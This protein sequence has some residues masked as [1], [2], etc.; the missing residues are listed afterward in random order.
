M[1][2]LEIILISSVPQEYHDK[3]KLCFSCD[4]DTRFVLDKQAYN[5]LY[6][7]SVGIGQVIAGKHQVIRGNIMLVEATG[8]PRENHRPASSH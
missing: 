4:D 7:Y 6:F 8:V 2:T 5:K 3:N 1:H